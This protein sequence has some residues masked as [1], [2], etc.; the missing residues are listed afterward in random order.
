[1]LGVVKEATDRD[2][3]PFKNTPRGD[4]DARKRTTIR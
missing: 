2:Y 1:M 3:K 4:V